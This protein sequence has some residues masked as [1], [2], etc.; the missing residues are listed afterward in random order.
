MQACCFTG[1]RWG[2]SPKGKEE[3]I[4]D[5]DTYVTG[6]NKERAILIVHDG[7]GWQ[8]QN[9]RLLADHFA[10]EVDATVYLPDFFRGASFFSFLPQNVKEDIMSGK[11]FDFADF[12]SKN[13]DVIGK[14][15]GANTKDIRKPELF[16]VA[17]ELKSKYKR[18]GA[19]GYCWGG[20]A[21]FQLGGKGEDLVD[22]VTVAHPAMLT[23]EEIDNIGVPIQIHA[24]ENDFTFTPELKAYSL[25]KIP[26]LNLPFSYQLH[27]GQEHGFASRGNQND[28]R[29]MKA[30]ILAKDLTAAWFRV[31]LNVDEEKSK[32]Q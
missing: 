29:E 26:K 30:M 27:P 7:S 32:K 12:M 11:P 6:T 25:E 5:S 17:K 14:F 15:M 23:T 10:D 21:C 8:A 16:A 13:P 24:P 20:W 3:R 28:P 22:C 2:G 9:N 19:T 1:F 31:F 18:V 4:A